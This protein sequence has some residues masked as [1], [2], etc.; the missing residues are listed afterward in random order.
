VTE[1]GILALGE[2]LKEITWKV[3]H[4]SSVLH[5]QIYS[6]VKDI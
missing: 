5:P 3:S 6:N 4:G 1:E 2:E